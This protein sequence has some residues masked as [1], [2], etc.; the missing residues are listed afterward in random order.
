MSIKSHANGIGMIYSASNPFF[1][2]LIN[3]IGQDDRNLQY[4]SGSRHSRH[5]SQR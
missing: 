3:Q 1:F 2:R 5:S 4:I